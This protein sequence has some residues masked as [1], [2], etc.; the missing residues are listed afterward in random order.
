MNFE[1]VEKRVIITCVILS[2][3]I[4]V[5]YS[6]IAGWAP[7]FLY[8]I[9]CG[10]AIMLF[11]FH[12]LRLAIGKY[13]VREDYGVAGGLYLL[14]LVIYGLAGIACYKVSLLC[15]YGFAIGVMEL[16]VGLLIGFGKGGKA[17]D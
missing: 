11:N 6:V 13:F 12:L 5:G 4:A 10:T 17:D 16:L 2:V 9:A 3:V 1:K 8:G 7:H 15:L 14:R